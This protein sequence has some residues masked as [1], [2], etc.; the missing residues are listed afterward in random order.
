MLRIPRTVLPL[1][2]LLLSSTLHA[3]NNRTDYDLDNDGL[4]EINDLQDLNE[5]RNHLNGAALYGSSDGCPDEGC[6]GFELTTDLNFDTNGDG[7]LDAADTYWNDG[8]GWV[9]IGTSGGRFR[10]VFDGNGHTI[11]NLMINRPSSGYQGLFAFIDNAQI[12]NITLRGPLTSVTGRSYV[13]GLAGVADDST[14]SQVI[15]TGNITGTSTSSNSNI[16]GLMGDT[17]DVQLNTCF[18]AGDISAQGGYVGGLIGSAESNTSISDCMASG[19][20][21]SEGIYSIGTL[22]GNYYS[23]SSITSSARR[24]LISIAGDP[25]DLF[26]YTSGSEL[27]ANY[28]QTESSSRSSDAS[29]T[30][31]SLSELQCPP[32]ADNYD[33]ASVT[34]YVDWAEALTPEGD[35]RWDF[36]SATQLPG[37]RINGVV[38]RDSDG[39]GSLDS[40]DA[41]PNNP[42]ASRDSDGD[43]A[44]DRWNLYCDAQCRDAS[45]LTLDQFP[46]TT[47]AVE[48]TDL[49][50]LPDAWTSGCDTSCQSASRLTL[51]DFP[52][53]SDN[54]GIPN[55][56][57]TD[58]NNDGVPDAAP[59]SDGLIDIASWTE[60]D[61]T[62]YSLQ[63]TG[64]RLGEDGEL[65]ISGCPMRIFDGVAM[66]TCR[67][68]EL[69]ND[70]DFDT[71][72]DGVL[73]AADTYWNDGQGWVAI[74]TYY[75]RFRAVF[76][77]NGHTISNLMI[78]RPS[79]SEQG[80]FGAIKNAQIQN[81][82]L[83]GPLTSVTGSSAVGALAGSTYNSTVTQ[84]VVA[85]N[86]RATSS[87]YSATG[88]LMGYT[89]NVQLNACFYAGDISSQDAYSDGEV[90]TG[91]LIGFARN[92]SISDCVTSGRV[93]NNETSSIGM[94]VGYFDSGSASRNLVS[95]AGDPTDLF[96]NSVDADNLTANYW[97]TESSDRTPGAS[98]TGASLGELQCPQTASN[99]ECT[100]ITLYVGW[101]D[102]LTPEGEPR[103]SFG[104]ATQLPTIR[105]NGVVYRDSDGDGL[106]DNYDDYPTNPAA[107]R[108]SD[109]DGAP[110][111][112]NLGCDAE[113]R[114]ASSLTLDQFPHNSAA[115]LD[116]DMDGQP[117]A[118]VAGCDSD[119]QS[120]S[121]LTLDDFPNDS[122]NDGTP[123]IEDTDDDNDG[124]PDA[125]TDSDGLIDIA[126]W[127]ELYAIRN[128]LQGF[129]QRLSE[130]GELDT[131]GCPARLV[132]GVSEAI[133]QG[134]EL[135]SDLNFDTNG[136]GVLD[137][138]DTYWNEGQGWVAIGTSGDSFQA[139]FEGNK[140]TISNLRINRRNS[141]YQGLFGAIKN[142][143]IQ[144]LTLRG[145]LTSVT[146]RSGVGALA[147][148][149]YNSTVG[150][151]VAAGT[152]RAT[153]SSYNTTGGL[154]G[155]TDNVQINACFYTG[156]IYAPG[157]YVGG[158]IGFA[159]NT[160]ISDC[161][162]SGR[163]TN[164]ETS[165]IGMLIGYFDSGSASRNLVSVAGDP[166]DLFGN[167]VDADN[168]TA[169]YWR[170]AS[171]NRNSVTSGT[172]ASLNE[173]QC[174]TKA[175]SA[176][177]SSVTL[178]AGWSDALAQDGTP[179][180]DFGT[181]TQLPGLRINGV[182]FRD[183]DGDGSLDSDDTDDDNDGVPDV[184][185]DLPFDP[186][187][188]T[189]SDNDGVGDNTDTFPNEPTE[190]A[191]TDNDGVGDN[192]D[193]FP[194]DPDETNDSDSDGVGDNSDSFPNDPAESADTDN[195]GIGDNADAFPEDPTE[196]LDTDGD[197]IGNNTDTDDDNDG[198]ADE[199]DPEL[200]PDNGQP[201]ISN[202][203][204]DL[205]RFENGE[206]QRVTLLTSE[207]IASDAAD[208]APAIHATLNDEALTLDGDTE[209]PVP[210]GSNTV[211]WY[212]ED[213]AG[214]RSEPVAQMIHVYP[215]VSFEETDIVTGENSSV[216]VTAK[217]SC[218]SPS[219]PIHIEFTA[220][221]ETTISADDFENFDM[222]TELV[223]D[224]ETTRIS[225]TFEWQVLSDMEDEDE[226]ILVL[227]IASA[228][229]D[230]DGSSSPLN[231]LPNQKT[232]SLRVVDANLPPVV[233]IEITQQD[234]P[235][236]IV[237]STLGDV[238]VSAIVTD[239]NGD[240]TH[241]FNWELSELELVIAADQASF[242][243]DPNNLQ[244]GDYAFKVTV[245]DSGEPALSDSEDSALT[246]ETPVEPTPEPTPTSP[247]APT[248]A[249]GTSGGGGS[250]SIWVLILLGLALGRRKIIR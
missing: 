230:I 193:A 197:G 66:P 108:D 76:D 64:Q 75:D 72:G 158:L 164:D 73:G 123:N 92:T 90:G 170:T 249:S 140:H 26:G 1:A 48:D 115:I 137:A 82:T 223:F 184:D 231:L 21:A 198:I 136:D 196:T 80:L 181:A 246:I 145:P 127:A 6:V 175:D 46:V 102:A 41:Y 228:S 84:V 233:T 191:D 11:Y 187:E 147:G 128:S 237:N 109:G 96:G 229:V 61:A 161:V 86:V 156:N 93:T 178:Y 188:S 24:N 18:F 2:L 88:G 239:P 68:Y 165:S 219:Y 186:N 50:G 245:T 36:G 33:C 56:E 213:A 202:V 131:S 214:N 53:D 101:A 236:D 12:R 118:W 37:I 227:N 77:G 138:S 168:L 209:V 49:D 216:S 183:S 20:V 52:N 211:S 129:G 83:R 150:Q 117:D 3:E 201:V 45:G 16:G 200:G 44:P 79:S 225:H 247:P 177:C 153:S 182:I 78:N 70:L 224:G 34:L 217:L 149:A 69:V 243:F 95:V 13:G 94:L 155:D 203:P 221:D 59:D 4:I 57:D 166:T 148:S 234:V 65:D 194:N 139:I 232:L 159:H 67:G 190:S 89:N 15:V 235:V 17:G 39:D 242:S 105:I 157:T 81:I 163:V 40:D 133:C 151:V 185:D 71:N 180:W 55:T 98:G 7:A 9:A 60:L 212:A 38:Y 125:D 179:I 107:N 8:E 126:S 120:S 250:T 103:W 14:I 32:T 10:A 124:V 111:S 121:G 104:S 85:G 204:E 206:T 62:R 152:V 172:G 87:S 208:T 222:P 143:Q 47:A 207:V 110:D 238:T 42:A 215:A 99:S 241:T 134:Y 119:C 248:G 162:T 30:G 154:I 226:E 174:P 141:S 58:D 25:T 91:G 146:G 43:G 114:N 113:C 74:G 195:D 100:S 220:G 160:S 173:L 240:D 130:D 63:G 132:N 135:V 106:L 27:I 19:S 35:P 122:D 205:V 22:V 29:G 112:W 171:G 5:I 176:E 199:D 144:N 169:N 218:V 189:D 51:D 167:P 142:A 192:A 54:D 31:A 116:T 28:W 23:F 244:D 210:C 97:Y